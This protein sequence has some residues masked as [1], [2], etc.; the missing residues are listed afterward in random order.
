MQLHVLNGKGAYL[1][2][3]PKGPVSKTI[4]E[5][6]LIT[7]VSATIFPLCYKGLS[8]VIFNA[9]RIR[10]LPVTE[11]YRERK[12]SNSNISEC[13]KPMLC[14]FACQPSIYHLSRCHRS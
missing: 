7:P 13:K 11:L 6:S 3:F 10:F 14:T 1:D 4:V 12:L 5:Y 9:F 8:A 2:T